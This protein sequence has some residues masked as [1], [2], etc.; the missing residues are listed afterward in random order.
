L[1]CA[2]SSAVDERAGRGDVAECTI[3]RIGTLKNPVAAARK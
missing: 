1:A 2:I 3:E